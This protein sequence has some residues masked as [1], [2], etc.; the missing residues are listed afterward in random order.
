MPETE[1]TAAHSEATGMIV[2][3]QPIF[4]KVTQNKNQACA[5]I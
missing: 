4:Q 3:H 5:T 2:N 1:A